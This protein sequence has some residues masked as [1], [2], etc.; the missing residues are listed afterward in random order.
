[1]PLRLPRQ[2][3]PAHAPVL[4]L[5]ASDLAQDVSDPGLGLF[6]EERRER[7]HALGLGDAASRDHLVE[8]SGPRVE[9]GGERGEL[10][11]ASSRDLAVALRQSRAERCVPDF[12]LRSLQQERRHRGVRVESGDGRGQ[13]PEPARRILLDLAAKG[14]GFAGHAPEP[15]V[16]QP[17]TP[18]P[19]GSD[20]TPASAS[21]VDAEPP[22][23]PL[24]PADL[25]DCSL[26]APVAHPE[27]PPR[28]APLTTRTW[29]SFL[30]SMD[31]PEGF[32]RWRR[33]RQSGGKST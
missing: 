18:P 24:A 9:T 22:A 21:C 27:A 8:R 3:R 33:L 26:E 19:F 28:T 10:G 20:L 31:P 4:D 6:R 17:E 1:D 11:C 12:V 15:R 16:H 2:V 14:P 30:N 23:D 5:V 32:L 29:N 13:A 7:R 25:P